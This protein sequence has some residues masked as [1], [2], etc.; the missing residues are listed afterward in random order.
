[1]YR[2]TPHRNAN[3]IEVELGG[4][5]SVDE[6]ADYMAALRQAFVANHFRAGYRIL[7]D[8]TACPIQSQ[9]MVEG[10]RTH[11]AGMPKASRIAMVT[12]SS[13]ARMQVRR[14]MTQDYARVFATPEEARVWL[15]SIEQSDADAV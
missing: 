8:V 1:M 9:E 15:A 6:V 10:M 3:L 7:I 2:I 4:M 13:L 5:M 12:G 14:L 11:M